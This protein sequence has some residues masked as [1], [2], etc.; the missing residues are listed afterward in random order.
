MLGGGTPRAR[1]Y[2]RSTPGCNRMR[3]ELAPDRMRTRTDSGRSRRRF[4]VRSWCRGGAPS[5][6]RSMGRAWRCLRSSTRRCI[7]VGEK[8]IRRLREAGTPKAASGRKHL[9]AATQ[10]VSRPRRRRQLSVKSATSTR[11]TWSVPGS[12]AST[13]STRRVVPSWACPSRIRTAARSPSSRW[14][15]RL[16]GRA[17]NAGSKP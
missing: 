11:S 4:A 3:H 5:A 2:R 1:S 12:T 16:S 17:P 8:T 6:W 9:D 10:R 14:M 7:N 15:T 13:A